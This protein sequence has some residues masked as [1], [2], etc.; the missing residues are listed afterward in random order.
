MGLMKNFCTAF[1]P[2]G[3]FDRERIFRDCWVVFGSENHSAY[4]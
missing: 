4:N 2:V 1:I 3:L